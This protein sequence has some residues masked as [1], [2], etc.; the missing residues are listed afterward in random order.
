MNN[1]IGQICQGLEHGQTI[2]HLH[3]QCESP[4]GC[5][6]FQ[7]LSFQHVRMQ[8]AIHQKQT[9]GL[10]AHC[11]VL[12]VLEIK[13]LPTMGN[14]LCNIGLL[15]TSKAF[16]KYEVDDI[17]QILI[18]MTPLCLQLSLVHRFKNMCICLPPV[19]VGNNFRN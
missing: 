5:K 14:L 10:T 2:C 8:Q 16:H 19:L 11:M 12:K 4:H 9:P 1:S 13:T 15:S 6:P 18:N 3:V 7:N 17:K